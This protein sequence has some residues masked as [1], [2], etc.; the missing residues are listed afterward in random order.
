MDSLKTYLNTDG[1]KTQQAGLQEA[2]TQVK[3]YFESDAWKKQQENLNTMMDK[4]KQ[5][6]DQ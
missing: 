5:L 4:Y 3:K 6:Q 1:W 2:M